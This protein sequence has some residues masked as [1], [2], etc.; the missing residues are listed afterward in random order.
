MDRI[1]A[2]L[3]FLQFGEPKKFLLVNHFPVGLGG[4]ITGRINALRLAIA[5]G[6]Q[7]VFKFLNDPPY[8]QT[9]EPLC[10]K[11]LPTS[12]W[13]SAEVVDLTSD[14]SDSDV[15]MFDPRFLRVRHHKN[16]DIIIQFIEERIG[17]RKLHPFV[18]DG[19]IL[20]WMRVCP[21]I[22]HF[23]D[24]NQRRLGISDSTLGVHFRRGD[25]SVETAFVPASEINRQISNMHRRWAFSSIYLA[26]DSPDA[27][28]EI[29]LPYGVELIF[30]SEE[31]RYNNANHKMLMAQPDLAIQETLTAY[32]NIALLSACGGVIG[33]DNAH[34]VTLS[35]A[36]IAERQRS[37]KN[38]FLIDGRTAEKNSI[39]VKLFFSMKRWVRKRLRSAFP[40]FT[41]DRRMQKFKN[42]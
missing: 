11:V 34:F 2:E 27:P 13:D 8:A 40:W 7:A 42:Q 21:E 24:V 16:E 5:L 20:R 1:H 4:Q 33:Q 19:I 26:S 32:K 25:K 37:S 14:Q 23:V 17:L 18:L 9:F 38:I 29:E 3:D 12:A 15:L 22:R 41:F 39:R 36:V 35:A 28:Q 10:R 31:K 6:R 30:D